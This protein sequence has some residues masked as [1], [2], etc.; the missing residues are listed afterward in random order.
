MNGQIPDLP[1]GG[2]AELLGLSDGPLQADAHIPKRNQT[3]FRI[4]I[5]SPVLRRIPCLQLEHRETQHIC[6]FVQI[7]AL[8]V[9]N[10]NPGIIG[11]Q[12]I[13][14]TGHTDA[15]RVQSGMNTP[16]DNRANGKFLQTELFK[17]NSDGMLHNY[18]FL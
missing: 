13:D 4:L 3:G 18:F 2:V 9:D 5:R 7:P 14:F 6:G 1:P 12:H 16:A 8:P 17:Y 11:D 10:L 15:L